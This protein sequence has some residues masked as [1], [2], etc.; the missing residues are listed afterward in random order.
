MI[1]TPEQIETFRADGFL[2]ARGALTDADLQPVIDELSDFID[3]R[4]HELKAEGQIEDLYKDAPFE[5]RY[6]LLFKQCKEIGKGMN[7]MSMRGRAMFEFL[8]NDN[9][10]D[11]VESLVGPE[12]TCN[13]IQHVRAKP[14]AAYEGREGPGFHNVPWHQDAGVMMVEAETSSVVTCWLPLGDAP[15]R[16]IE[17]ASGPQYGYGFT[18]SSSP[19]GRSAPP[20]CKA[21]S[22]AHRPPSLPPPLQ[23]AGARCSR[24]HPDP[25][26]SIT[27]TC[28]SVISST[29]LSH[30]FSECTISPPLR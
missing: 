2:I 21:P 24:P 13:P 29:R 22:P 19:P 3:A 6:G 23:S 1:L 5:E 27:A 12:I 4:A 8:H 9:L 20:G 28:A 7:I 26:P 14:P 17:D 10:L 18:I 11:V 30:R 25:A 16:L 15:K